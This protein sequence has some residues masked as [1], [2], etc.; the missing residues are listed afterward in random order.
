[1]SVIQ[2]LVFDFDTSV[3]SKFSISCFV[4]LT[5]CQMSYDFLLFE[6]PNHKIVH[7]RWIREVLQSRY[8]FHQR[9]CDMCHWIFLPNPDVWQRAPVP[10]CHSP[11]AGFAQ[12]FCADPV[13]QPAPDN[14]VLEVLRER[15]LRPVYETRL[16]SIVSWIL[17]KV[18]EMGWVVNFVNLLLELPS[19]F[20]LLVIR[21][22]ANILNENWQNLRFSILLS[23][24]TTL[25]CNFDLLRWL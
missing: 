5:P 15:H 2:F 6:R 1:M 23:D 18:I 20:H 21:T 7:H 24:K 22:A 19:L 17:I 25:S 16:V 3:L 9:P 4:T 12:R 11:S 14:C 13:R 8:R 10:L